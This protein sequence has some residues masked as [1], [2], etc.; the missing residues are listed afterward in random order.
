[1]NNN[2]INNRKSNILN[3]NI[4]RAFLVL[5]IAG[6]LLFG[7][8]K[9][10]FKAKAD[11][12]KGTGNSIIASQDINKDINISIKDT[13]NKQ[14]GE[15]VMNLQSVEEEDSIVVNG[16]SANAIQGKTFLILNLKLTN[17][18]QQ[19]VNINTRDYVRLSVN[20]KD[21]EWLAPEVYNDPVQIQAIS[22]KYTR[23][24]FTINKNDTN[25]VLQVGEILGNKE[26]IPLN[27]H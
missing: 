1:M 16:Q 21:S 10:V 11:T 6:A 23:L 13:N 4:I 14:I 7:I 22:T 5:I 19:G 3:N 27:L 18:L 26:K 17:A 8:S 9:L 2:N 12:N 15:I 24:G 25:L 20:G